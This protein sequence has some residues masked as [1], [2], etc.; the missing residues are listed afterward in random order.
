M[1]RVFGLLALLL[2]SQV[3]PVSAANCTFKPFST[4]PGAD[5]DLQWAAKS[6]RPCTFL[7]KTTSGIESK[8]MLVVQQA[9][10]GTA[11]TP[12]LTSIS[13]VSRPGFVGRDSFVVE[14]TA[15]SLARRII[16]G[17]ARWTIDVDVLP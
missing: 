2:G 5:V 7:V 17:T 13:Y 1:R 3:S 16:R 10:H 12:T 14:R 9:T 6:G 15:E 11:A 8:Q 4:V